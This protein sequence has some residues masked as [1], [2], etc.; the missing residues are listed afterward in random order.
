MQYDSVIFIFSYLNAP[1]EFNLFYSTKFC[2]LGVLSTRHLGALFAGLEKNFSS[3]DAVLASLKTGDLNKILGTTSIKY[4]SRRPFHCLQ[5][6]PQVFV[7]KSL[8]ND[9]S[10]LLCI[11]LEV[12]G[13]L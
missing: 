2:G 4:H 1:Y 10:A 9:F 5:K 6:M 12:S 11:D 3:L 8:P 13:S 7:L